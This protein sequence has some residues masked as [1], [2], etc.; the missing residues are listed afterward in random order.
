MLQQQPL[1]GNGPA[2][3]GLSLNA[4]PGLQPLNS[5]HPSSQHRSDG[6]PGLDGSENG[7][8]NR[9]DIGDI[10]QQ[11]MTITDQSLDEAQAKLD[12]F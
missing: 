11:I 10:L 5:V 12:I 9:R 4:H 7:L 2:G 1:T 8:E 3:R 6:E